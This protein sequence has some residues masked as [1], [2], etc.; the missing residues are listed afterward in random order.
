MEKKIYMHP[1]SEVTKVSP[2]Y[3]ILGGIPCVKP[4]PPHP[5]P[6]RGASPIE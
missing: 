5:A 3:T 2:S 6:A 4:V 1:L